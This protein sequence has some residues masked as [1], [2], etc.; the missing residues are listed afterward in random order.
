M[1]GLR[2][3]LKVVYAVKRSN[4]TESRASV[5]DIS[6]SKL[7][8]NKNLIVEGHYFCSN[9]PTNTQNAYF[10]C[11]NHG[12]NTRVTIERELLDKPGPHPV[13]MKNEHDH[14]KKRKGKLLPSEAGME[15]NAT[16]NG[17]LEQL[18]FEFVDCSLLEPVSKISVHDESS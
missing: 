3:K 6:L 2:R 14:S 15:H 8:N 4:A 12:C 7:S 13:T 11:V 17:S 10:K 18:H 5:A 9:G 16:G 1:S